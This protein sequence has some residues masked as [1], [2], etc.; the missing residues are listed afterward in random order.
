ML[1]VRVSAP[2]SKPLDEAIRAI[3]IEWFQPSR[4]VYWIDLAAS[5][6]IGWTAFALA[7][8]ARAW[9]RAGFL[10]VATFALYRAVLF[11]HE[12][13]HRAPRDLPGFT[14]VWNACVGIP[15]MMPSFLY[16]GVHLDHH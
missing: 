6:A 11:I 12:L 2:P 8:R 16:Q 3:P 13:T 15:L 5:A 10:V 4:A 7:V 1:P 14:T 9:T